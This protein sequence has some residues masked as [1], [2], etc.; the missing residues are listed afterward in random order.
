[1]LALAT[2]VSVW[3]VGF[4]LE[5]YNVLSYPHGV[6]SLSHLASIQDAPRVL[7]S[8]MGWLNTYLSAT[9]RIAQS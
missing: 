7:L 9:I 8:N 2:C 4:E 1:M 6:L 5:L 3:Y